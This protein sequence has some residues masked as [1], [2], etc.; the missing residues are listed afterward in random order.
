MSTDTFGSTK[1]F[2][3]KLHYWSYKGPNELL[4]ACE[5]IDHCS[6]A[7]SDSQKVSRTREQCS[8]YYSF[9]LIVKKERQQTTDSGTQ[10]STKNGCDDKD[11]K[12]TEHVTNK[13]ICGPGKYVICDKF[14]CYDDKLKPYKE[15]K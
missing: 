8:S 4:K 9:L 10:E 11:W 2:D 1:S 15:I 14:G 5:N 13:P 7:S 3:F 6:S 12:K